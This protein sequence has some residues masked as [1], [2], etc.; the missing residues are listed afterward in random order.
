MEEK[1]ESKRDEDDAAD[2]LDDDVVVAHPTEH[3]HR[4]CE[5]DPREQE[6]E[7]EPGRVGDEQERPAH[8]GARI[9]SEDEDAG[10]HRAD[11]RRRADR[12]SASEQNA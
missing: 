2:P 8:H 3:R 11:A 7:A 12:E 10:E 1:Q 9:R 4:P 6:G 5:R